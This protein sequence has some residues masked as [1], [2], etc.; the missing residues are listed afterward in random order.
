MDIKGPHICASLMSIAQQT[1]SRPIL[2]D[3]QIQIVSSS[4]RQIAAAATGSQLLHRVALLSRALS[5]CLKITP[6]S[7]VI[8]VAQTSAAVMEVMLSVLDAGC[9]LCPVNWRWTALELSSAVTRLSPALILFDNHCSELVTQAILLAFNSVTNNG[10]HNDPRAP[11]AHRTPPRTCRIDHWHQPTR[12]ALPSKDQLDNALSHRYID[13]K[14]QQ[15]QGHAESVFPGLGSRSGPPLQYIHPPITTSGVRGAELQNSTTRTPTAITTTMASMTT[16]SSYLLAPQQVLGAAHF[17][18]QAFTRQLSQTFTSSSPQPGPPFSPSRPQHLPQLQLQTS[19][20]G[21]AMLVFTSGT[22]SAPKAVR[23][24]HTAFHC[25]SLVKLALV[26]Y[27]PADTYLHLAPLS[28]IGGLS[29]AFA[30]LMAGCTQVFMPRF[31]PASALRIIA[32]HSVSAF[33]AVPT[34]LQDLADMARTVATGLQVADLGETSAV[35]GLGC[36]RRIL[37]GAGGTAPK[38]QDAVGRTFPSAELISAYGMTEACSSMTFRYLRGSSVPAA[39]T[40]AAAAAAPA[41]AARMWGAPDS[42]SNPGSSH[43]GSGRIPSPGGGSGREDNFVAEQVAA[44]MSRPAPVAPGSA[45]AKS[46]GSQCVGCPAP[47][48]Q[49]MIRPAEDL[50]VGAGMAPCGG[51]PGGES[52]PPYI[53]GE[54]LT[55]GPHVML[56]YWEDPAA[57]LEA[58]TCDGWLRTGDLGYLAED[59]ALWLMGRAKDM[60]KS[61]GENVFAPQVEAVLSNHPAV[62]AVAVVGLPDERLGEMVA[63]LVVL[64]KGWTFLGPAMKNTNT[65]TSSA[66]LTPA[67]AAAGNPAPRVTSLADLQAHCRAQGM[68]GFRLPRFAVGQWQPLPTNSSGKVHKAV[69]RERL[70]ALRSG[71]DAERG[72]TPGTGNGVVAISRL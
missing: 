1:S 31:E 14:E 19:P 36:V 8:L 10:H 71:T 23:L 39:S 21:T 13:G 6:G 61:G 53:V 5:T 28:H 42:A 25:Q 56:G 15:Q 33:I 72:S 11:G 50:A 3:E 66:P 47:G 4:E 59:G 12:P 48:V 68:A 52:A 45:Q 69:V 9:V 41:A 58:L 22:T 54:V 40:S 43:V 67:F 37:V 55:R 51:E 20:C 16:T 2:I 32:R 46:T 17:P 30:A 70:A 60:I 64:R 62:E 24:S 63:A 27:S 57:S 49:I 38:V 35:L 44:P 34:M 18:S 26:G 29:S 7:V 65:N